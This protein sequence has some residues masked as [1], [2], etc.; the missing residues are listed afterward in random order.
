MKIYTLSLTE[1]K[2]ATKGYGLLNV[3]ESLC[4]NGVIVSFVINETKNILK[5]KLGKHRTD[6]AMLF[7]EIIEE[8]ASL[9][10][11]NPSKRTKE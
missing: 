2:K 6:V 3:L 8:I 5:V 1:A 4:D 7:N 10:S 11:T 9:P